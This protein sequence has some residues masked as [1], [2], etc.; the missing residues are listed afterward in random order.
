MSEAIGVSE[1]IVM[2]NAS[3]RLTLTKRWLGQK[4]KIV[5]MLVLPELWWVLPEPWMHVLG[6][7]GFRLITKVA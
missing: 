3:V 7:R 5:W 4:L 6:L 1:V 2:T